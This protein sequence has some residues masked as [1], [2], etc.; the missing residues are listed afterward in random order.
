[1]IYLPRCKYCNIRMNIEE[2]SRNEELER[3]KENWSCQTCDDDRNRILERYT[4]TD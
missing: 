2:M 1:M 4:F 3:E